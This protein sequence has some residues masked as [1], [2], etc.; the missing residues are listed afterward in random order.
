[1]ISL[2]VHTLVGRLRPR[3]VVVVNGGGNDGS[4]AA[5]ADAESSAG[6]A[7]QAGGR[8]NQTAGPACISHYRQFCTGKAHALRCT[9]LVARAWHVRFTV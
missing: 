9:G 6:G 8:C 7:R 2:Q 1:M 3:W 5:D 4:T